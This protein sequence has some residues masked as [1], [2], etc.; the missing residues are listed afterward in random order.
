MI[1]NHLQ[2]FNNRVFGIWY[3][4]SG[5]RESLK[6]DTRYQIP[7]T[8]RNE[9]GFTLLEIMI[10]LAILSIGLM[11]IFTAQGTSLRASGRAENIQTASM[12]AQQKMT[13]KLLELEPEIAKGSFPD[14][15]KN[16]QGNFDKPLEDFRWEFFVKKVE[17]PVAGGEGG[18]GQQAPSAGGP[19]AAAPK[20]GSDANQAPADAQKN[21]AQMVTKK[22]SES[23]RELSV[24]VTWK[25]LEVEQSLVVT[26]HI[27]KVP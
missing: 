17:I 26:T 10:A 16:D 24:K 6:P 15:T 9:R 19:D 2:C 4:V 20:T 11:A 27:T 8:P 23:V 1:R 25:E 5:R 21:L 13:E 12:L 22:I 7:V 18:G 3:L 14:D